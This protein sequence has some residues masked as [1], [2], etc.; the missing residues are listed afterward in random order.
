MV[1]DDDSKES[2]VNHAAKETVY[3]SKSEE[4]NHSRKNYSNEESNEE[5]IP[6]L[7]C[8]DFIGLQIFNMLNDFFSLI[9]HNP[10]HV[11]PHESFLDRV[12]VF[13]FVG[14]EMVSSVVAAPFDG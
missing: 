10:S 11:R 8:E 3:S 6:V 2:S 12:R 13:L 4:S 7:P 14:L 5:D 9:D 1:D